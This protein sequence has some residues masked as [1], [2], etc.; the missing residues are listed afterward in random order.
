MDWLLLELCEERCD[1][2]SAGGELSQPCQYLG[3][4]IEAVYVRCFCQVETHVQESINAL[5]LTCHLG[6]VGSDPVVPDPVGCAVVH[7]GPAKF[8][9][10]IGL[11]HLWIAILADNLGVQ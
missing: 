8:H 9:S 6:V 7:K 4:G 10:P 5:H 2:V 1:V 3:V 11:D